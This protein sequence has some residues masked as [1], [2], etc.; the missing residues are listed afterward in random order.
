MNRRLL[1]CAASLT[2]FNAS[3]ARGVITY[4]KIE[5]TPNPLNIICGMQGTAKLVV[6]GGGAMPDGT[7]LIFT[8]AKPDVVNP[9]GMQIPVGRGVHGDVNG[10]FSDEFNII[11]FCTAK[12]E[13][14]VGLF[15]QG[16]IG[17]TVPSG[18]QFTIELSEPGVPNN[19][20][21]ISNFIT[22]NC[23]PEPAALLTAALGMAVLVASRRRPAT[24]LAG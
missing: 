8:E 1:V 7:S 12:P 10:D 3:P 17:N 13:C 24:P 4:T 6:E 20:T 14:R 16:I 19:G 18:T 15:E 21:D 2:L 22:V 9:P 23:V 11:F 5:L